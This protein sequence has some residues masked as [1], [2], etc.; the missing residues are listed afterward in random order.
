[1]KAWDRTWPEAAPNKGPQCEALCFIT[2][3]FLSQDFP[4]EVSPSSAPLQ[5]NRSVTHPCPTASSLSPMATQS[6]QGDQNALLPEGTCRPW[7]QT[8][9]GKF[10]TRGSFRKPS[11]PSTGKACFIHLYLSSPS[12]QKIGEYTVQSVINMHL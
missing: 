10:M 8:T 5:S 3:F 6:A 12:P 2:T 4:W 9:I 11:A 1:M 7:A